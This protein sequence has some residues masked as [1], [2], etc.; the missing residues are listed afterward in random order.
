MLHKQFQAH[1]LW[2]LDLLF[3]LHG[4]EILSANPR[5]RYRLKICD[6][7]QFDRRY[8]RFGENYCIQFALKMEETENRN[9]VTAARTSD[10]TLRVLEYGLLRRTFGKLYIH[11][12]NKEFPDL[13]TLVINWSSIERGYHRKINWF[14]HGATLEWVRDMC[15]QRTEIC[16]I[17]LYAVQLTEL[18]LAQKHT[19]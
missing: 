16:I 3:D 2:S 8:Q 12:H 11:F 4:C 7:L 9:F 6:A 18:R 17:A 14:L 5:L 10:L 1:S 15:V 13:D 19:L